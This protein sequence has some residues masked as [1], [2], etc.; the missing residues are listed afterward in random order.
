MR[1]VVGAGIGS[2]LSPQRF[3]T[4]GR[5]NIELNL[6]TTT[7]AFLVSPDPVYFWSV[8]ATFGLQYSP[9]TGIM[10]LLANGSSYSFTFA[11][12][13]RNLSAMDVWFTG[14]GAS[15]M[16][17]QYRNT[18][19]NGE[20]YT[21]SGI[22]IDVPSGPTP[23]AIVT[24]G[25]LYLLKKYDGTAVFPGT[26]RGT[27]LNMVS[28]KP[29]W[30]LVYPLT[31]GSQTRQFIAIGVSL[32][33]GAGGTIG[34]GYVVR[35]LTYLGTKWGGT[36]QGVNSQQVGPGAGGPNNGML[37]V[38]GSQVYANLSATMTNI[39]VLYGGFNDINAAGATAVQTYG[40]VQRYFAS[41]KNYCAAASS[42]IAWATGHTYVPGDV[43]FD[44]VS[45]TVQQTTAG[46]TSAGSTPTF[47][48]TVDVPTT[49]GGG[50]VWF[51]TGKTKPAGVFTLK[52]GGGCYHHYYLQPT[53]L[54][55]FNTLVRTGIGVDFDFLAFDMENDSVLGL[56]ISSGPGCPFPIWR[57]SDQI[58]GND[59]YYIRQASLASQSLLLAAP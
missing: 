48:A 39:V 33:R 45:N 26:L 3:I 56:D 9:S 24:S 20:G 21:D 1:P 42:A 17:C 25:G 34:G 2:F 47:S 23:A 15:P 14:G 31:T 43:I 57:I 5:I 4:S 7:D 36:N 27:N 10:T 46:G 30:A 54:P 18:Y 41:V 37:T 8:N 38:M 52:T 12:G 59:S 35:A 11:V 40:Y 29:T 13:W 19:S 58:H 28:G 55:A 32:T 44:S 53:V 16:T 50:V 51:S 6:N 49:D 22:A